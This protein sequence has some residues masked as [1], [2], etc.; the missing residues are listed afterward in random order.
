MLAINELEIT[1][2]AHRRAAL[3]PA[4]DRRT[5]AL[6]IAWGIACRRIGPAQHGAEP[7]A[8]PMALSPTPSAAAA[9]KVWRPQEW[10]RRRVYVRAVRRWV[11]VSVEAPRW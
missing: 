6:R 11:A 5:L 7:S 4:R 10:V 8:R 9:L 1:C 2:R 3:V